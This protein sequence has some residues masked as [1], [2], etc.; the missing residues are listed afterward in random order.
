MIKWAIQEKRKSER[1]SERFLPFQRGINFTRFGNAF[2]VS[3]I[4][5]IRLF[6]VENA[7]RSLSIIA[8]KQAFKQME[9]RLLLQNIHYV[10]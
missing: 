3:E 6:K 2:K 1:N 10:N 8:H 4:V 9:E 5:Q 7:Q